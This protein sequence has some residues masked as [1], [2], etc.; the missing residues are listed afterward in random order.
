MAANK[1][2]GSKAAS[3]AG[4]AL[5]DKPTDK[6]AKSAANNGAELTKTAAKSAGAGSSKSKFS[7]TPRYAIAFDLNNKA[8]KA[9]G[10]S[11]AE[12]ATIYQT[13]IPKALTECGFDDHAQG[14]L[15]LTKDDVDPLAVI[16]NLQATLDALAPNFRLYAH[17]VHIFEVQAWSDVTGSLTNTPAAAPMVK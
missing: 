2:T 4:K 12:I 11:R 7:T 3:S 10:L 1:Q 6:A 9:D 14:S 5:G 17:R 16:I 13:E 8:M 15:Y